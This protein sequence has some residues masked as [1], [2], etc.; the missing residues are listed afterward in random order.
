MSIAPRY[1]PLIVAAG[2]FAG[3]YLG[4]LIPYVGSQ[5]TLIWPPTG[6]ALAALL[7]WRYRIIPGIWLGAFLVNLATGA[8]WQ[9]AL[10]ISVGNVLGPFA[11]WLLLRWARFDLRMDKRRDIFVFAFAG[12]PPTHD[13]HCH[14]RLSDPGRRPNAASCTVEYGM[15][16][17]V[18]GRSPGR[19]ALYAAPDQL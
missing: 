3:G 6:I 11:A 18:V 4:L 10:G 9:A 15:V 8:S 19:F 16:R 5:I 2:Y 13:H 7:H 12:A 1:R 14:H 17:M